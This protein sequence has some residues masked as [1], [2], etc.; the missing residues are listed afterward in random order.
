MFKFV[1]T[2]YALTTMFDFGHFF[3]SKLDLCL[4]CCQSASQSSQ[5]AS[6]DLH[7]SPFQR[8]FPTGLQTSRWRPLGFLCLALGSWQSRPDSGGRRLGLC[9]R[10][11]NLGKPGALQH[12]QGGA[13]GRRVP[14]A[15]ALVFGRLR[16][17]GGEGGNDLAL[18]LLRGQCGG[19]A[20]SGAGEQERGRKLV[21]KL[22]CMP[23]DCI[24]VCTRRQEPWLE[25]RP[26]G[27]GSVGAFFW[28]HR[29]LGRPLA[30][31]PGEQG[32]ERR[33]RQQ[34]HWLCEGHRCRSIHCGR[35]CNS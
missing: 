19:A 2:L 27:L 7:P 31:I 29:L 32:K 4:S 25:R 13:C 14:S 22:A 21:C 35:H 17:R 24:E 3:T 16:S 6:Q 12:I 9:P 30:R 28:V 10:E 26:R 23:G 1:R 20:A 15:A 33:Q 11:R 5:P 8:S 18:P 34:G